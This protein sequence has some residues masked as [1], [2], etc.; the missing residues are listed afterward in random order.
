ME[1]FP[2]IENLRKG[3]KLCVAVK[4]HGATITACLYFFCCAA[5]VLAL[6]GE[7]SVSITNAAVKKL[8]SI[9]EKG[10]YGRP[11]SCTKM[12]VFLWRPFVLI[13]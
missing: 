11:F 12:A 8:I 3:V 13:G 9:T 4:V 2:G 6:T 10:L 1:L 7:A 5:A